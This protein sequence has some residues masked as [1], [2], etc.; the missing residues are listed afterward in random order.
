[1]G[2]RLGWLPDWARR[3]GISVTV[4]FDWLTAKR[5]VCKKCG[6]MRADHSHEI[7]RFEED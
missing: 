5:D 7:H 4:T 2:E 1:M 3:L 6:K